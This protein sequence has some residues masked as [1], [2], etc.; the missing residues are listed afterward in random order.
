MATLKNEILQACKALGL[1]V[2]FDFVVDVGNGHKILTVAHI[3]NIG[4]RN[5][6]LI[7]RDYEDVR[8]Y[9]D[10]LEQI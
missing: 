5:G 4:A 6:M 3:H 8:P 10:Y 1:R 9:R 7:V 2:D